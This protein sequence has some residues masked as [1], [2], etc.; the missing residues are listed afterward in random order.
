MSPPQYTGPFQATG[1]ADA[2][3]L[4]G[5]G[6][7]TVLFDSSVWRVQVPFEIYH[8]FLNGPIGAAFQIYIGT[9]PWDANNIGYFNGW[10]GAQPIPIQPSQNLYFYFNTAAGTAPVVTV[11]TRI[12]Q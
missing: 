12:P 5:A 4:I 8:I 7:W 3:N 6:N 10:D 11:W 9:Y 1:F 2:E